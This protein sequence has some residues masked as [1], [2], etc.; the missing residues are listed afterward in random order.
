MVKNK[1]LL[2]YYQL[3]TFICVGSVADAKLYSQKQ[4]I[5]PCL[6]D[7]ASVTVFVLPLFVFLLLPK[8]KQNK[9]NLLK[10]YRL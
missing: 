9:Q 8:V 10:Q 2:V 1:I 7:I 3:F 6:R 4:I 5:L